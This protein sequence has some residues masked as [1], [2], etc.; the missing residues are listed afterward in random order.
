MTTRM[1][2]MAGKLQDGHVK[3]EMG[4]A[5]LARIELL[6]ELMSQQ[7]ES[8]PAMLCVTDDDAPPQVLTKDFPYEGS[9]RAILLRSPI[10]QMPIAPASGGLLFDTNVNRLG[11]ML[12][13]KAV[14]GLTIFFC[15][16]GPTAGDGSIWIPPNGTWDFK[17]GNLLWCGHIFGVPDSGNVNVAA[18]EF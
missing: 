1:A 3:A 14:V 5:T 8:D 15:E 4:L 13:N 17:L 16:V 12:V 9:V 10:A 6:L 11:G 2:E 18:C 7:V